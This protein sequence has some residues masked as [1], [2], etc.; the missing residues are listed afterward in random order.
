MNRRHVFPE[1]GGFESREDSPPGAGYDVM[2]RQDQQLRL[3][4][5]DVVP[6]LLVGR[7]GSLG[8]NDILKR[9]RRSVL[10]PFWL[11]PVWV[12]WSRTGPPVRKSVQHISARISAIFVRR[13]PGV[14]SD[15]KLFGRGRDAVTTP[16]PSSADPTALFPVTL[17]IA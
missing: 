3:A 17:S 14:E 5:L 13:N 12:S 7:F 10:G 2:S 11:P 8:W 16:N 9:Y 6:A 1:H 4:L 15:L